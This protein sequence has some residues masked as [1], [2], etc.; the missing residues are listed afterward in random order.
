[1]DL[2]ALSASIQDK[3]LNQKD[4]EVI[5][6]EPH[7]GPQQYWQ[8]NSISALFE[9]NIEVDIIKNKLEHFLNK[10]LKLLFLG[11]KI[12]IGLK[13]PKINFILFA[14]EINFG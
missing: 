5:F 8:E 9:E 4:E 10:K 3:N 1:M 11:L 7:N 2:G 13:P 6:G 12:K 14:F